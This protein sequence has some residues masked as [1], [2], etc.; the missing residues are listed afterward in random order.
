M[1]AVSRVEGQGAMKKMTPFLLKKYSEMSGEKK[2]KIAL[3]L[4]EMV[5]NIR[6]E[7]EIAMKKYNGKRSS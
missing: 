1:E 7:G 4:S 3:D 6:R 2:V 5:R